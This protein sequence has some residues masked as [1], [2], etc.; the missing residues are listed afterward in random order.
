MASNPVNTPS[1]P[2]AEGATARAAKVQDR[3]LRLEDILKLMVVDGL[4]STADAEKLARS[5]TQ[6]FEGPLELIA[7]Q[8]WHA[9][10]PP[11]KVLT[12]DAL[13]EWLAGK[14]GVPYFHIDPLK[15]DLVAVTATM[16]NAYAERY[17][18]LPVSVGAGILTV[19]TSEPFI[20]SWADELEQILRLRIKFVFANPQD[21]RRFLGEFFNLARSMKKAQE[22]SKGDISLA[23]NFEQ[24]VE[25]GKS[26]GC[27]S[28]P[29]SSARPTYTSSRGAKPVSCGFASTACC[30]RCTRF[31]IRF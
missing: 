15:I 21:I 11:R 14:L 13:V 9:L 12:L 10:A 2:P 19:A 16:S 3:R 27:G 28:T 24:L 7:D 5:R 4:V 30:I 22:T 8:K 23:R 25:L 20:R 29:S 17:R 31:R 6:R 26:T 18:I 1:P